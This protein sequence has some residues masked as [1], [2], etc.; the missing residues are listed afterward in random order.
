MGEQ[1]INHFLTYLAVNK[2]VSASTQNQALCS[3]LFLYKQVI[4][5]SIGW[6]DKLE[7]AKKP[8]TIPIILSPGEVKVVAATSRSRW[9]VASLLYGSGLRL[10]ESLKMRVKDIDFEY[11]HI[12]I[13]D[14]KGHKYRRTMLPT[15]LKEPLA[16]HLERV[17]VL[18]QKDLDA[19]GV[20][21]F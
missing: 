13:R 17:K 1:E 7:W 12:T 18:H 4:K 20:S 14:V 19:V 3:I 5:K 10:M 8:K 16:Q 6:I 9:I 21:L 11:N 2:K 15:A